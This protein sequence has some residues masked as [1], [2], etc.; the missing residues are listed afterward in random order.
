MSP[1]T[2]NRATQG[3]VPGAH[4]ASYYA[5]R[6]SA[7]LI[8]TEASQVSPQG[9]GYPNTPGIHSSEQ[10]EGWKQVTRAVHAAD[11]RIFLQLWHVGRIS[12]PSLQ[13][14]GGL[15]VAPSA[16]RPEGQ[17]LTV[18][19]LKPF[20]TP[21]ALE[22]GEIAG[23]VEQFRA[24][25]SNA[26]TAGFDG[27]EIHGANGYL[28][29]QFLRDKTNRR[30]DAYGGSIPNRARLLLEVAEALIDVWGPERVGVRLSP[31]NSFNDMADSTPEETFGYAIDQL[32]HL[33]LAFLDIV[34]PSPQDKIPGGVR[35]DAR[36][37][38]GPWK[39]ALV[40][41][42]GYDAARANALLAEGG[43]DLV[44]FG[45]PFLANPDLPER[46]RRAAPLNPPDRSTFYGGGEAGY[47]DY[48]FL[49]ETL[50]T[51]G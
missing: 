51:A 33:R 38:R 46:F 3:N 27:V 11:G 15:P 12:H 43:A 18:E 6:A 8:I 49:K 40:A 42:R 23:I 50:A 20:V 10:V 39:Q 2:R 32:N 17:A 41:N 44:A 7:G 25:A 4:S 35:L 28:I 16:V 47:T 45:V 13:Q 5:Q 14:D 29:D 22:L 34:E 30:T 26:R 31:L 1:M 24:G 9:V 36:Y 48:P 37:F 21:R 19:G